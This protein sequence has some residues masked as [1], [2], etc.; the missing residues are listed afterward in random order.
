MGASEED[1]ARAVTLVQR[2]LCLVSHP[3]VSARGFPSHSRPAQGVSDRRCGMGRPLVQ[4]GTVPTPN[5]DGPGPFC[6]EFL[7][8]GSEAEKPYGLNGFGSGRMP[9]FGGTLSSDGP[10][11]SGRVLAWWKHGWE[12]V[13]DVLP[14]AVQIAVL[15]QS[16][17]PLESS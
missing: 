15:G 4:F 3:Q 7:Q 16:I 12:G 8:K 13:G 10:R 6:I 5:S 2:Q 14:R 17:C 11:A 9:A 1:A